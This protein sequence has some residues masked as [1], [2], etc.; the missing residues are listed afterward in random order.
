[1]SVGRLVTVG[2]YLPSLYTSL[3]RFSESN[4]VFANSMAVLE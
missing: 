1:M 2:M 3:Q 4:V